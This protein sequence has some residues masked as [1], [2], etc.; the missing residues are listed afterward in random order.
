MAGIFQ[1]PPTRDARAP[2]EERP[3]GRGTPA[4]EI[5]VSYSHRDKPIAD[6]VVS[7]LEQAGIR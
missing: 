6:A 2:G 3:S 4:H 7:R 5:F 1:G